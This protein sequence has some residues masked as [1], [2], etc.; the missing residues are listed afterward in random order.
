MILM[1]NMTTIIIPIIMVPLTMVHLYYNKWMQMV[2]H[3]KH[4]LS[5][6]NEVDDH[7]CERSTD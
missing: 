3:N 5:Y 1:I 7:L 4:D 2:Y 6:E